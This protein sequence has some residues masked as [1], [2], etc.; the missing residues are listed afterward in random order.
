[1]EES[2]GCLCP[3]LSAPTPLTTHH[4]PSCCSH[5]HATHI[6]I[7]LYPHTQPKHR[8]PGEGGGF[9]HPLHPLCLPA[10][11]KASATGGR[12]SS[13]RPVVCQCHTH[14]LGADSAAGDRAAA[15]TQHTAATTCHKQVQDVW[16]KG[17]GM[18]AQGSVSVHVLFGAPGSAGVVSVFKLS[19]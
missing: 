8:P 10:P 3:T 5:L 12:A 19:T 7:F 6:P 4:R 14:R 1:M 16:G 15:A 13:L 11:H 17:D 9:S 2:V 18:A